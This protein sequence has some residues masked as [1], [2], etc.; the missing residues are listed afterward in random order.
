MPLGS[1][2]G[3]NMAPFWFPK[4]FKI[5]PKIDPKRHQF[6]NR[7]LHRFLLVFGG[8]LG[9]MLA[10]FSFKMVQGCG[11]PP[12]FLLTLC[13]FS[14]FWSSWPPLG[15]IWPRFGR[16]WASILDVFGLHFGRFWSR[17]RS[18]VACSFGTFLSCS[19]L[20]LPLVLCTENEIEYRW[21]L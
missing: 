3:A 7:F 4:S 16:V 17:F 19:F 8:Q 20:K 21:G 14:I 11:A 10:T 18:H 2:L 15:P 6:F 13:Y 5:L 12:L 9:A 1:P